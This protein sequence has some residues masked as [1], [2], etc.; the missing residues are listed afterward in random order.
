MK[1]FG[2]AWMAFL[3]LLS[4]VGSINIASL[5]Y[6]FQLNSIRKSVKNSIKEN[7]NSSELLGFHFSLQELES[8]ILEWE[9]SKEFKYQGYMYDIISADTCGSE[10]FFLCFADEEESW[11]RWSFKEKLADTLAN[12]S[13]S[14]D[15]LSHFQ[16]FFS[17]MLW[18]KENSF[19]T[20]INLRNRYLLENQLAHA[21]YKASILL[22]PPNFIVII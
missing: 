19:L 10:V 16:N 18:Q 11:F 22:P 21:Q 9:H 20:K 6:S 15:Y 5:S 4:V 13:S 3:L 12:N 8:D 1:K 2:L 7:L 17:T 14:K